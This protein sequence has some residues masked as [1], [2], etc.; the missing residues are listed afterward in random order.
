MKF[1][2][3]CVFP[4]TKPD[5]T[6]ND[7]GICSA[8]EFSEKKTRDIDWDARFTELKAIVEKYRS[9][10]NNWDCIVPVSGGKD[11]TFQTWFVKEKLGLN[12]LCVHFEPTVRTELGL[13]N[14]NALR[15]MGVDLISWDKNPKVYKA[16][17]LEAFRRVGDH[18]WPN[19]IGIFTVPVITAVKFNIP[20]IIWGENSQ[21]EYGGPASAQQSKVLD[22]RWLEEFGGLLGN[23]ITD[24]IGV[25][26]I[27]EQD[28]IP[29]TYPSDDELQ[30]VG[31]TG[32]FLGHF[33]KWDARAQIKQVEGL[34]WSAKLDGPVEGTYSNH[35]N[36]DEA[37]YYIH[38]YLKYVKFG[39]GRTSDHA[40]IDIRNGRMTREEACGLVRDYEGRYPQ[41]HLQAFLK[42]YDMTKEE[43]DKIVDS[44]TNKKIFQRE[45]DGRFSRQSDGSLVKLYHPELN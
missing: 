28:V 36:L 20:L 31:V 42:Y 43:F 44:Y 4:D 37:T 30:R 14:L 33:I 15:S 40:G 34:G 12:P 5:L 32:L 11:S 1:C 26:G 7:H 18:E 2:K 13:R 22:R 27:R 23:R 38:D 45:P 8:C 39:F 17:G 29:Y 9:K 3:K 6:F 16:M 41:Q 25:N 35:E 24:M 21:S 10:A 19:H